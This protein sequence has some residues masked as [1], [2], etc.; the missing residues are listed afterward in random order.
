MI[1]KEELK[2][3]YQVALIRDLIKFSIAQDFDF[4]DSE[5]LTLDDW[6]MENFGTNCKELD[7][8]TGLVE[9]IKSYFP[10]DDKGESKNVDT[11]LFSGK[12]TRM[13]F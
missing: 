3:F 7:E 11:G 2:D 6:L 8:F 1:K 4:I 9:E 13:M 5:Y 12:N 10:N